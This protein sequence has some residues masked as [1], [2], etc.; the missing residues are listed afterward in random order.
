L[1]W[2]QNPAA[3]SQVSLSHRNSDKHVAAQG[4]DRQ[5]KERTRSAEF[6]WLFPIMPLMPG[7]D[8]L[9]LH[10]HISYPTRRCKLYHTASSRY[11]PRV[12][13]P[14]PRGR[15]K[16]GARQ[17][18]RAREPTPRR[19]KL[20]A[21]CCTTSYGPSTYVAVCAVDSFSVGTYTFSCVRDCPGSTCIADHPGAGGGR[22]GG[23]TLPDVFDRLTCAP[24]LTFVYC[25]PCP[26]PLPGQ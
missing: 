16:C 11:F 7:S 12:L 6:V 21:R 10:Y 15:H 23:G 13:H 14:P 17:L 4:R 3:W 9:M 8:S 5:S 2:S 1:A 18:Q 26:P 24:K 25:R 22:D 20:E 19:R